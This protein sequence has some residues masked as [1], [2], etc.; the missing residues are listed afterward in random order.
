MTHRYPDPF[1]SV[2]SLR[3]DSDFG[4]FNSLGELPDQ[5]PSGTRSPNGLLRSADAFPEI[6]LAKGVGGMGSVTNDAFAADN[7]TSLDSDL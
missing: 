2:K 6:V 4:D 3:R 7:I 5:A 1:Y